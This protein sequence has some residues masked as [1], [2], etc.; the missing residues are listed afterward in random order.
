[1]L[2]AQMEVEPAEVLRRLRAHAYV[3]GRSLT[4]VARDILD[5]G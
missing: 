3:S 2:V 1:M 4:D 5:I